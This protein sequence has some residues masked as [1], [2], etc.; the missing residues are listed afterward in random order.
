[1]KV[2]LLM[3]ARIKHYAGEVVECTQEEA[4][5]LLSVG[6]AE[7]PIVTEENR[8]TPEDGIPE[9]EERE[10]AKKPIRKTKK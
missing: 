5:F 1:M 10:T 8:V 7:L 3:D 9:T 6:A 2:K 4:G